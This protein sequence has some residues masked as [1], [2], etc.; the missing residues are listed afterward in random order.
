M[1]A[2]ASI[3]STETPEQTR[4]RLRKVA[5]ATIFG[6][7]LEWYDFY[8]YATK[9]TFSISCAA[10]MSQLNSSCSIK[11]VSNGAASPVP[12]YEALRKIPVAVPRSLMANQ[13]RTTRAPD[14]NCGASPA[15]NN[16][17]AAN[18]CPGRSPGHTAPG[19]STTR[20]NR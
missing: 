13:S 15:P 11:K 3:P 9:P 17:R 1:S 14:G 19:R 18:N 8:L 6:S 4:K 7:M 5:A 2:P 10:L 12:K 16:A 20:P